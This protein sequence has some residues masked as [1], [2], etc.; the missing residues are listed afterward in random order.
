MG[1]AGVRGPL[2][3]ARKFRVAQFY[4]ILASVFHSAIPA[5]VSKRAHLVAIG[6]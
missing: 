5:V 6:S 4:V 3:T 2:I 1:I